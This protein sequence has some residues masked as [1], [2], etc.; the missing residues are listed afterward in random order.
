MKFISSEILQDII[1]IFIDDDCPTAWVQSHVLQNCSNF[2]RNFQF[3]LIFSVQLAITGLT[4]GHPVGAPHPNI[5]R[6]ICSIPD[7]ISVML[8][9]AQFGSQQCCNME[10]TLTYSLASQKTKTPSNSVR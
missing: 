1:D 5:R 9:S 3:I 2:Q 4:G 10:A 6:A 7:L 8:N